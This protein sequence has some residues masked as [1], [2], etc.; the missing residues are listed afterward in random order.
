MDQSAHVGQISCSEKFHHCLLT[1]RFG[2]E[3]LDIVSGELVKFFS[4][5]HLSS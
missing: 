5:H 4:S 2:N 3:C 1:V